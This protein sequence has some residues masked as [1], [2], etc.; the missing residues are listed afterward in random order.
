MLCSFLEPQNSRGCSDTPSTPAIY[1]PVFFN[2]KLADKLH[3][4]GMYIEIEKTT[5][6]TVSIALSKD[7]AATCSE[8]KMKKNMGKE[9]ILK[10]KC[11][12][13]EFEPMMYSFS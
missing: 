8:R 6:D 13:K 3:S 9:D 7:Q 1:G 12:K 2:V 5:F 4:H 10:K 11:F